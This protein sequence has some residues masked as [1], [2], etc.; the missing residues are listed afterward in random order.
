[1]GCERSGCCLGW[2]G[3][4]HGMAALASLEVISV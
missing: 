4:F 3:V 2:I 1:V